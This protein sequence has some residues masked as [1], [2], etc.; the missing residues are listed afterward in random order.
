MVSLCIGKSKFNVTSSD[1]N[2]TNQCTQL[3][4]TTPSV[5]QQAHYEMLA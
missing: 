3:L 2:D 4:N 1:E 5:G